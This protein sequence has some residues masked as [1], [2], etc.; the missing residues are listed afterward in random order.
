MAK[1]GKNNPI[2]DGNNPIG[3]SHKYSS[4]GLKIW[5]NFFLL[6]FFSFCK[7]EL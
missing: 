7:D 4:I 1:G 5:V 6:S 2:G 3:S